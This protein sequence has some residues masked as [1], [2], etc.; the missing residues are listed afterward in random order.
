MEIR[1]CT[2]ADYPALSELY[3]CLYPDRPV[4]ADAFI[5]ADRTRDP[6]F[7]MKRWVA[8]RHHQIVGAG[9]YFQ[10]EWFYHPR[11]FRI[12]VL[13]HP[14]HR[15]QGIGSAL[16]A[17]V[18]DGLTPLNPV[19]LIADTYQNCP[20]N[21]RFLE[22]RGF[23]VFIRD[24]TL[25]LDVAAFDLT[26]YGDYERQ[27]RAQ[28]IELRSATELAD[29]PNRDQKLYELDRILSADA[30]Q[31]EHAPE[32]SLAD[33]V[34]FAITGSSALPDALF[35]ALHDDSYVGF[36]QV[37]ASGEQV[38]YQLLTGVRREYR[39]RNIALALKLRTIAYAKAGQIETIIT[40]NDPSNYPMLALNERLGFVR[41]PDQLFF[42]K[43]VRE[44]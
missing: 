24:C 21:I 25:R 35:V 23:E 16:Y 27:L 8:V 17:Q 36:T 44:E 28:H 38:L 15:K 9:S 22:S 4:T 26:A 31:H 7:Q 20:E 33:Y 11:K 13:V 34:D 40:S 32:R 12:S 10:R 14:D 18:L 2:P 19:A 43:E 1:V 41:E 29:D 30:P 42:R 39:R 3:T 5:E 6:K 37:M